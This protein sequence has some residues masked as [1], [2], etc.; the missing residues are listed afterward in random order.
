MA[1]I[2]EPLKESKV[3]AYLLAGLDSDYESLVTT[4]TTRSDLVGLNELY[5]YLLSHETH[6]EKK[7]KTIQ[8][9]ASEN[10]ASHGGSS[11]GA[12]RG[13]NFGHGRGRGN[14]HGGGRGNN[15]R[16][17]YQIYKRTNHDA[18]RSYHRFDQS[19]QPEECVATA[20][21]V[22]ST[23]YQVNPN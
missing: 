23:S 14:G 21:G 13:G 18:S 10:Q 16:P 1:A 19:Y 9:S 12:P 15:N 8:F 20:V 2:G 17:P 5:G 11:G 4:I 3:V 22:P 7:H 6:N